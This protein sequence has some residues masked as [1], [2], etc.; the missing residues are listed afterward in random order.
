MDWWD[1]ESGELPPV[2]EEVHALRPGRPRQARNLR[3]AS[4]PVR[5]RMSIM[6]YGADPDRVAM[7]AVEGRDWPE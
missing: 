5:E 7:A 6:L 4:R 2:G 1:P 3:Q